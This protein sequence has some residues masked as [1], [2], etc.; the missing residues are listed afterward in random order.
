MPGQTDPLRPRQALAAIVAASAAPYGYTISIWSSGAVLMRSH[1]TPRVGDV[2]A[3]VA[4]AVIAFALLALLTR[5]AVAEPA[6]DRAP[7]RVLAGTMHLLAA[8][9]AVG[10]AA[11]LAELGGWEAWPLGSFAATAIYLLGAGAELALVSRLMG[12]RRAAP[13]VWIEQHAGPRAELRPLFELAE[14]SAAQ[15]DSY[16]DS[17]RVFVAVCGDRVVGHVQVTETDRQGELEIKNVAVVASH[18]HRGIGRALVEAAIEL[19]CEES[20]STVLVATATADVDNLR[21]YQRLGFRMRSIE[22]DA[23]TA[24]TG[25]GPETSADGIEL[26]DR[27]WLELPLDRALCSG[28]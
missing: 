28:P 13:A 24:A 4:G 27:A 15:L 17:G 3:F 16:L 11:L 25:Y 26:R 14:D 18:R 19:A 8:G 20:R 1:G 5:G 22:R 12:A 9:A 7:D 21:F 6:T 2:F 10:A 23:F